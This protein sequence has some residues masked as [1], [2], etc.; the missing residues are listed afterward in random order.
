MSE[1][2]THSHTERNHQGKSNMV[3]FARVTD[4]R[5][6]KP[7]RCRERLGGFCVITI[8][9]LRESL[10]RPRRENFNLTKSFSPTKHLIEGGIDWV[11]PGSGI[12]DRIHLQAK[13]RE[14]VYRWLFRCWSAF[15][16]AANSVFGILFSI[17]F[18]HRV[19]QW[20]NTWLVRLCFCNISLLRFD[21]GILRY[22]EYDE[23]HGKIAT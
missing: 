13:E 16:I 19:I 21:L 23:F 3:L 1:Y 18:G 14:G 7:V 6:L 8:R 22:Y 17:P 20:T 11:V 5:S 4:M 2:V 12:E 10:H 9:R 15:N